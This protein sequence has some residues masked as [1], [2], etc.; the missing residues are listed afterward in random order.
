MDETVRFVPLGHAGRLLRED[1]VSQRLVKG[2]MSP[3]RASETPPDDAGWVTEVWTDADARL[4]VRFRGLQRSSFISLMTE[5]QSGRKQAQEVSNF[6][7]KACS[8][9]HE[10]IRLIER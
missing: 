7:P 5:R 4:T 2:G 10:F 6:F 1:S 8:Q 3:S 9:G